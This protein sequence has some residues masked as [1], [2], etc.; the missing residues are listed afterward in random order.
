[1]VIFGV[2]QVLR[3]LL[4]VPSNL[5]GQ[6]S[7]DLFINGLSLLLV[8]VPIWFFSWKTC[9]E[10]VAQKGESDS[11]L[12]LGV[13]YLLA[14]AGVAVVLS[15][16]GVV[17][18]LI[19]RRILGES[20]AAPEFLS[21]IASPISIALPLG[22][23]WAYYGHWLDRE[24]GSVRDES[25]RAGLQ[26][27]YY[28]ILSLAGLVTAFTG[29]A[30]LVTFILDTLVG[31]QLWGADLRLRI[32]AALAALLIGLPLWL[33]TWPRMQAQSQSQ[34]A[35]GESARR[36]VV[37][38]T[39]LYLVLF[40]SVI[41][42]MVFAVTVVFRLLQAALGSQ[43]LDL[44]AMLNA[45]GLLVLFAILLVYHLKCLRA[46]GTETTRALLERRGEFQAL[47][48]ERAG[49]GFGESLRL[50]VQKH[51]PGLS[52]TVL[53]AGRGDPR[54]CR[55]RAGSGAALRPG[56]AI[57]RR[58]WQ[59]SSPRIKDG[60]SSPPWKARASCGRARGTS[61]P[62]PPRRSCAS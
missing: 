12:R 17:L 39:Y 32:S 37:R 55:L 59:N 7:R 36:S 58:R 38:K 43:P 23:V 52:L 14:L 45:L 56:C 60:S 13:L 15:M 57:L 25:R 54:G 6:V 4:Y 9:Q 34:D 30:M 46:D 31:R 5:L 40:A 61:P 28:Y 19:L 41:G 11:L 51:A 42:G 1:M 29:M 20:I 2:Q 62:T 53:A 10:A 16:T 8:G 22:I 33:K 48:F 24:I 26:R 49:S 50:A 3:F 27:L 44:V 18:G 35:M 47:V 21:R